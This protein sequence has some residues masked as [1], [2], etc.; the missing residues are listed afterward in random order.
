MGSPIRVASIPNRSLYVEHIGTK[1]DGTMR[2]PA[3]ATPGWVRRN[4]REFD[5]MHVQS[6]SHPEL[7]PDQAA[8]LTAALELAGKPLAY[9]VHA[10]EE[11]P[12]RAEVQSI[13]IREARLVIS[14]TDEM[15]AQIF[16]REGRNSIVVPHPHVVPLADLR[17]RGPRRAM[18][19][20]T[21]GVQLSSL[22]SNA[23]AE[24][25]V[26][27]V[28]E[29][30]RESA[31]YRARVDVEASGAT[32]G[33]LPALLAGLERRGQI[34]L[35]RHE[36]L[37]DE[38]VIACAREIDIA[39]AP[40]T[41]GPHCRWIEAFRDLGAALVVPA[42][43]EAV[44]RPRDF[45]YRLFPTG[46]PDRD[47]LRSAI[48]T[49]ARHLTSGSVKPLDAASRKRQRRLIA[50]RHRWLYADLL[51]RGSGSSGRAGSGHSLGDSESSWDSGLSGSRLSEE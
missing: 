7:T 12:V 40:S 9:T 11:E 6:G 3:R 21:L 20:Y 49:A 4:A 50:E 8:D 13:L 45:S 28:A 38:T 1:G 23:V 51:R 2:M 16:V 36:R 39:V 43:D 41:S 5:L 44:E 30:A 48:E 10:L 29:R 42:A 15:K 24:A 31:C 47:E 46:A 14:L 34:E 26:E 22:G 33:A 18:P 19:P 25:V 17:R 32:A 37:D 35:H 27:A